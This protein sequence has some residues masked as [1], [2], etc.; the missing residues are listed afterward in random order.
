M[1][2]I[3][4]QKVKLSIGNLTIATYNDS[5]CM[6]DWTYRAMRQSIDKRLTTL[7]NASFEEKNNDIIERTIY[8]LEEYLKEERKDFDIPL[9]LVGTDFQ[10]SVWN[11]L[12]KIDYG[13]TS[14]YLKQSEKLGNKD[15]IRAVA[16]ANGANAISIIVPCHRIVGSNGELI[17]YAGGL[18]I[19]QKLLSL[20]KA[21]LIQEHQG[22]MF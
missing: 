6:C 15:A 17:G 8:Q 3:Q 21:Q 5:L 7:L 9:L 11:E 4:F 16:S 13:N 2:T 10:K 1:S 22:S 14:T 20:E 18:P 12:L 19:K